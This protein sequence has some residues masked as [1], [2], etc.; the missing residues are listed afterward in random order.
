[1]D[2]EF[3]DGGAN[4]LAVLKPVNPIPVATFESASNVDSCIFSGALLNEPDVPVTVTGGCSD[5]QPFEVTFFP[6]GT[7]VIFPIFAEFFGE[8][9]GVIYS[10]QS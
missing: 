2:V 4:D 1:L 7:D 9:I 6:P 10:K 5:Q 8:K 3:P